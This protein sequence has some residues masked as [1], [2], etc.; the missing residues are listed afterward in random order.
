MDRYIGLDADASSCTVA[1]VGPSGRS[2][3][4]SRTGSHRRVVASPCVRAGN[5]WWNNWSHQVIC[6]S[7]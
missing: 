7:L 2:P 4:A 6:I 5:S 3:G 1:T